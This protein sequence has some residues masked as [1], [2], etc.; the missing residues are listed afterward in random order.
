ML[1]ARDEMNYT[2]S[3]STPVPSSSTVLT[4]LWMHALIRNEVILLTKVS[5]FLHLVQNPTILI[6]SSLELTEQ[7]IL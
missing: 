6:L 2:R 5:T 4:D 7:L 1:D 3:L